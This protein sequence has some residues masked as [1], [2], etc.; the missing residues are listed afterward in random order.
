MWARG[1]AAGPRSRGNREPWRAGGGGLTGVDRELPRPDRVEEELNIFDKGLQIALRKNNLKLPRASA[2]LKELGLNS[3]QRGKP[4][5]ELSDFPAKVCPV[6][7]IT[8][9]SKDFENK[10]YLAPLTTVGNLPFRRV[11]KGLGVDITCG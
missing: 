3:K 7:R 6:D 11:C 8:R 9:T 10:L 1:A 5:L 2:R 4:A